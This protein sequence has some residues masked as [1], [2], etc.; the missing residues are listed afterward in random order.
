ME[1]MCFIVGAS[2][3]S[4]VDFSYNNNDLIIAS[5]AGYLFLKEHNYRIDLVVGDFD[6]LGYKP[7]EENIVL[8]P[9]IK[10]ITDTHRAIL[11]GLE[12]G[13]K[14]FALVG[15]LYGKIE[16]TLANI[17]ELKFIKDHNANASILSKNRTITI[18]KNEKIELEREKSLIS[19]FSFGEAKGVYLSNL[20]YELNDATITDSFPLGVSN[21]FINKKATIRVDDGY[22]L[23]VYQN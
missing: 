23:V 4:Q 15:C 8:L 10:D 20:K 18:L 2:K 19:I 22:L 14:N 11:E 1:K 12:K 13:Y 3:E 16:H 6:S 17:Q 9:K 21:E 5:D 7:N